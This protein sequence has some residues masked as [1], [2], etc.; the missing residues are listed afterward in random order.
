MYLIVYLIK[1][2]LGST[3]T[4]LNVHGWTC[5]EYLSLKMNLC[6]SGDVPLGMGVIEVPL[7]LPYPGKR[8][9]QNWEQFPLLFSRSKNVRSHCPNLK[10]YSKYYQLQKSI[11]VVLTD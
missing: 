9:H 8:P 5:H 1:W 10:R 4:V 7:E 2:V 6:F 3:E 11:S